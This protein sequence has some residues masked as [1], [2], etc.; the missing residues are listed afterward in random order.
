M[1]KAG[2]ETLPFAVVVKK[3]DQLLQQRRLIFAYFENLSLFAGGHF[4]EQSLMR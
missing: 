2:G 3:M 1:E 4:F